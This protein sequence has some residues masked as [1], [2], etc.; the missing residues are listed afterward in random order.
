MQKQWLTAG[1]CAALVLLAAALGVQ[2]RRINRFSE[3]LSSLE[4]ELR[5]E[6]TQLDNRIKSLE[7]DGKS[8]VLSYSAELAG[9]DLQKKTVQIRVAITTSQ[10]IQND[11]SVAVKGS[12]EPGSYGW[13]E[14]SLSSGPDGVH[15]S[16]TL[17]LP[18]DASDMEVL[19]CVN[20]ASEVLQSCSS[21]A[22]LLPAQLIS[23]GGDVL[24]NA[25]RQM[26]YQTEWSADLSDLKVGSAAFHIYKNG[27]LMK[28]SPCNLGS[29]EDA[30][31]KVLSCQDAAAGHETPAKPGDELEM[32]FFCTDE[33]GIGYEY[34]VGRWQITET[35]AAAHWP[36]QMRPTLT[37]PD[38]D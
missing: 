18:M 6:D 27:K 21:I 12:D 24:Y 23:C 30:D 28:E 20:R 2:Q 9:I 25:E 34:T 32:R 22:D 4:T 15:Y 1:L 31:G 7:K 16:A 10:S 29:R 35:A 26:F 33:Y 3:Q 17:E 36:Q 13:P 19:L 8:L 5:Q 38:G 11:P 37:W 14:R